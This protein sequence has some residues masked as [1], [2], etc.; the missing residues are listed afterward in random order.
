MTAKKATKKT[1]KQ[2]TPNDWLAWVVV[3]PS[4]FPILSSVSDRR[5][6]AID[7]AAYNGIEWVIAK[8]TGYKVVRVELLPSV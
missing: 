5:S 8:N 7:R 4:G 6:G 3:N 1:P 2:P